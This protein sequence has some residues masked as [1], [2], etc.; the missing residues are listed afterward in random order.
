MKKC[1]LLHSELSHVIADMGHTQELTIGDSGLPVPPGVKKID[2]AVSR[3]IPDFL[4]VLQAVFTELQV[5][6]VILAEEISEKNPELNRNILELI[7][8]LEETDQIRIPIK[9]LTH[10]ELKER[11]KNSCA[12][13][14]T[15]EA[16]PFANIILVS[17]VV[18]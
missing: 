13:V 11:T 4:S 1:V 7:L 2:L 12:V 16:T 8:K 10:Q 3:G 14:R 18:F 9:Y 5:E 6:Q 15:G 17:G